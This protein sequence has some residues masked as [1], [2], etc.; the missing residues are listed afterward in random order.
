MMINVI[1]RMTNIVQGCA[2]T[3]SDTALHGKSADY[4]GYDCG[5]EL[6]D[7]DNGIPVYLNHNTCF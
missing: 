3:S 7:L 6:K 5:N 4:R 2:T 1:V